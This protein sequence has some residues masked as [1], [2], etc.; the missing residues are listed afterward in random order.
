MKGIL[1]ARFVIKTPLRFLF[2]VP[3]IVYLY[4]LQMSIGKHF[5]VGS[6]KSEFGNKRKV[7]F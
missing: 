6:I 4:D 1:S 7:E 2:C 5:S 3:N